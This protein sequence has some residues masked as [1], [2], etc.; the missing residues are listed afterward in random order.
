MCP[1]NHVN[2]DYEG[3]MNLSAYVKEIRQKGQRSFT[4]VQLIKDQNLSNNAAINAIARLRKQGDL[5]TPA[6]G[7]YIIVPPEHQPYGSIPAEELVPILMQYLQADYYVSLLSGAGYHGATHQKPGRFQVITNKR[8]KHPLEFGRVKLELVYKKSLAS[9]PIQNLTVAT[10]YLKVATPELVA[11]D[12]LT[13]PRRSG[14]LN[15]IATVLTELVEAIDADKLI[16][17]AEIIGEKAQ[18]QRLGYILEQ[19]D[20]MEEEKKLLLI[21]KLIK[22]LDGKISLYVPLAS[23]LPKKSFPR[24]GKWRIIANTNIESDL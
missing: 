14:G 18:L 15:H 17:L 1:L 21:D 9:L 12:L 6:K 4:L 22:Y 7:L 24:I 11:L 19:L 16:K 8:V 23:E 2:S 20:T 5:I 10:G 3:I 13:Y